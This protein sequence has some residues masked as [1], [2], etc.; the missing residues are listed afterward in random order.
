M[1][2]SA[3]KSDSLKHKI[4]HLLTFSFIFQ[5]WY[6]FVIT[7]V[8]GLMQLMHLSCFWKIWAFCMSSITHDYLYYA[9]CIACWAEG[10]CDD[11]QEG[12]L[13]SWLHVIL[14]LHELSTSCVVDSR[15]RYT[16]IYAHVY[17]NSD[18]L[19]HMIYHLLKFSF[20]FHLIYLFCIYLFTYLFR[21]H[22]YI[23]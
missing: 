15:K 18:V 17:I 22:K 11:N 13:F 1:H 8:P 23:K 12:T 9:P 16:C 21:K 20:V 19:K 10:H 3:T 14:F 4:Y 2:L 6:I 5:L 7:L